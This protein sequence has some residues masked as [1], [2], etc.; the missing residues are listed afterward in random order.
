MTTS[1]ADVRPIKRNAIAYLSS[2]SIRTQVRD[3]DESR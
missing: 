2:R 1:A 3:Q